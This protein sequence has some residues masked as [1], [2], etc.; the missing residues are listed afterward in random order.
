MQTAPRGMLELKPNFY[1]PYHVK[2][3]RRTTKEQLAL[4]EG[5]FKTTPKPSSEVRKS[6]AGRLSMTARE[7]Q[8][9]FQ[10]R[11]AKQK[12]MLLRASASAPARPADDAK[13][14]PAP[15]LAL[16]EAPSTS[17]ISALLPQSKAA[18]PDRLSIV[19]S[20]PPLLLSSSPA[21]KEPPQAMRR[22]SD[23]PPSF[24][25]VGHSAIAAA[26]A[27][28]PATRHPPPPPL[29]ATSL[30]A[31]F[32]ALVATA[33]SECTSPPALLAPAGH[34]MAA[35]AAARPTPQFKKKRADHDADR[36]HTARVHH[37]AFDGTN[38][39]PVKPD[40]LMTA[41]D[42]LSM[43][44]PSNLP[45]FVMPDPSAGNGGFGLGAGFPHH[46]QSP[47]AA[48]GLWSTI[49]YSQLASPLPQHQ[50]QQPLPPHAGIPPMYSGMLG[51]GAAGPSSAPMLGAFGLAA[52][53]SGL[54]SPAP[55]SAPVLGDIQLS[56][57][58]TLA[59]YQTLLMITNA[60][61]IPPFAVDREASSSGASRPQ[62]CS[63]GAMFMPSGPFATQAPRVGAAGI[64]SP[65]LLVATTG[66]QAA[67]GSNGVGGSCTG[68]GGGG[69]AL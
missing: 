55:H 33:S 59:F 60:N 63:Q 51:V 48:T 64:L 35:P 65:E 40:A 52:P 17:L 16:S 37:E 11:R 15:A 32:T 61:G 26:A 9:W 5:T 3:R 42:Q 10:N 47:F 31:G 30:P 2:H 69:S 8:I 24:V 12:N 50:H 19:S 68:G 53:C 28:G 13:A 7:V 56:S 6:L 23:V 45:N 46:S 29:L 14:T 39:L 44:D 38:K 4:L 58:Q 54:G 36:Y 43:L 66:P 1:N 41:D 20:P 62:P 67:A 57:E 49:P 22:H 18:R 34:A 27:V 21:A 25:H